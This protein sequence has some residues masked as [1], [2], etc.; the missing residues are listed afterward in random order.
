MEKLAAEEIP[1]FLWVC[2]VMA[3]SASASRVAG[4]G[5]EKLQPIV[6]SW[7]SSRT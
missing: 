2:W 1:V 5:W 4:Y 6:D 7:C 3:W